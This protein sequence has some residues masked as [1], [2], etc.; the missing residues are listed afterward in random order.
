MRRRSFMDK[1]RIIVELL[2]RAAASDGPFTYS[3][4][5]PIP[6]CGNRIPPYTVTRCGICAKGRETA[7]SCISASS[8]SKDENEDRFSTNQSQTMSSLPFCLFFIFICRL[9][10]LSVSVVFIRSFLSIE[11]DFLVAADKLIGNEKKK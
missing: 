7:I 6:R 1:L 8:L 3:M 10:F 11:G 4:T 5:I 2:A 9:I